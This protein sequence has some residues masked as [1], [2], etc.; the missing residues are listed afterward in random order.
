MC[1]LSFDLP[2][3]LQAILLAF[4]S[5]LLPFL[6]KAIYMTCYIVLFKMPE[7]SQLLCQTWGCTAQHLRTTLYLLSTNI[8]VVGEVKTSEKR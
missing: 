8:I 3:T 7:S 4:G 1:P 6:E 2:A 5:H